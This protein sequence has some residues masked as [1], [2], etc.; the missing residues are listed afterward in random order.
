MEILNFLLQN[1]WTVISLVIS[2][3]L[4]ITKIRKGFQFLKALKYSYL[5]YQK[6]SSFETIENFEN[7]L[8]NSEIYLQKL[9]VSNLFSHSHKTFVFTEN[10]LKDKSQIIFYTL[11]AIYDSELASL[12]PVRKLSFKFYQLEDNETLYSNLIRFIEYY[13]YK[14]GIKI[15]FYI[16]PSQMKTDLENYIKTL[17]S[18]KVRI[19]IG[20]DYDQRTNH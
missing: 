12:I 20:N 2:I 5:V 6:I 17:D 7:V 19:L 13:K 3:A 1:E 8:N 11:K 15:I 14:N 4:L 16:S 10:I 18:K 9:K